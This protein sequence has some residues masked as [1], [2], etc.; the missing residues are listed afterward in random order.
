MDP[1]NRTRWPINAD[2]NIFIWSVVW[3]SGNGNCYVFSYILE[4]F[5]LEMTLLEILS[6]SKIESE[7]S[8]Y[9]LKWIKAQNE[10][11]RKSNN[12]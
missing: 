3:F 12:E 2:I 5:R 6:E 8:V 11:I 4:G 1:K 9:F 7:W 10:N